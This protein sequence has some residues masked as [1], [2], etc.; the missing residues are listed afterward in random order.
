MKKKRDL[1]HSLYILLLEERPASEVCLS[2]PP[3]KRPCFKTPRHPAKEMDLFEV[4]CPSDLVLY[5]IETYASCRKSPTRGSQ[6]T[7][8]IGCWSLLTVFVVSYYL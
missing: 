6:L 3:L 7:Q 4:D 1:C 8:R 2:S 5:W